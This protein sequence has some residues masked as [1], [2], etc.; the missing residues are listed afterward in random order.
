MNKYENLFKKEKSLNKQQKHLLFVHNAIQ[1]DKEKLEKNKNNIPKEVYNIGYHLLQK[2][3]SNVRVQLAK[4]LTQINIVY[5]KLNSV[6]I[7][8][9]IQNHQAPTIKMIDQR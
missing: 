2:K 8:S 5:E 1:L 7:K 4:C 3:V 9:T 6:A